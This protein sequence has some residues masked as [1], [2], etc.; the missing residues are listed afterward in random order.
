MTYPNFKNK[1][2]QESLYHPKD[3]IDYKRFS[4]DLPEKII[5]SYQNSA[6]QHFKEKYEPEKIELYSLLNIYTHDDIGFVKMTGIGAPNAVAIFEE[7]IALG[8]KNFLNIGLAGGLQH[9]GVFLCN[10]ALRDEGTSYHYLPDSKFTFPDEKLTKKLGEFIE[11]QRLEFFEG[12]TWTIDAPYRE[13]KTE[14]EKYTKMGVA[15]V[16]MESSALFAVAQY[17]KVK[18]AS[19]FVVSDLLREMWIPKFRDLKV[20]KTL[21]VLIDVGIECLKN[22]K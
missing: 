21:N 15:T 11:K 10:K 7:L 4:K 18:I 14:I 16:E 19:V 22:L 20:K 3:Y 5:I 12:M 13:T 1:Y 8:G 9:E 2:S 17:R 6:E